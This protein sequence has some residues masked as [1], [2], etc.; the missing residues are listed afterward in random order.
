VLSISYTIVVHLFS[1][2]NMDNQ[3]QS[4]EGSGMKNK[5]T[6]IFL[7]IIWFIFANKQLKAQSTQVSGIVTDA[8]TDE[9]L[10]GVNILVKGTSTGA[11]TDAD[12]A[13]QL[14]M[15]SLQDTIV[16]SYIGYQTKEVPISGRMELKIALQPQ[17]ISGEEVVVVGYGEQSRRKITSSVSSVNMEDV[18]E[19]PAS[20]ISQTLSGKAAGLKVDLQSAQP[21]GDVAFQIRGSATG[22][23]PLIV[24]D[25][26]PTSDF[27]PASAGVFGKGSIDA[28]LSTLNPADIKSIDILKDASATAI[29][30]SKAAGGVILITTKKGKLRGESSFD[31]NLNVSSG[32]QQFYG[33]PDMLGAAEYMRETNGVMKEEWLY[34]SRKSVY[35]EVSK[36]NGWSEPGKF[37]P[38]YS[39]ETIRKFENGSQVG[40]DFV[41][42]VTRAGAV[43]DVN[44]SVSG[45][46][47]NTRIYSS[48][49]IY[50]QK[51]IIKDNDLTKYIGRLNVNQDFGD[52]L[53][54][55]LNVNYSQ[56]NNNN[57]Q[58]GNGGLY[59]NSGILLSALQFDPTLPVRDENGNYQKNIRQS[60]F[61]NPV[62][63]LD[64]SNKTE[65]E[66]FFSVAHLKYDILPGLYVKTQ[67]G[68]DRTKSNGYGY[69][70]TSTIAGKSYNGRADRTGNKNTNYQFQLLLNY[71]KTFGNN[72]NFTGLLGTEY[73]K[74]NWEGHGITATDFPY[75]GVRWNN[76]E[77]GANRPSV[78]SNGGASETASYFTR[79]S[80]NYD[81]KYF[82]TAN[83]RLDGSSNF[84]PEQQYGF[85]PGISVG[86][87]LSAEGF[88]DATRNWLDQLKLRVGYGQTGNDEI[89]SAFSDWYA[90]GAN[91]MWGN[92]VVSGIKIA[93]L[94]NPGLK[95]EKQVDIN[96]GVDFALFNNRVSGSFE[97]FNRVISRIL[98]HKNLVSSNPVDQIT[99]NLDA[100]KQTY[101]T[102]VTVNSKNIESSSFSWNSQLTYS[103]YRDRWLERDP[104][105]VL[106]I[107]ESP[108]QYFGELWY[109]KSDG[110]VEPG[111]TGPLNHIP[112]TVR[113]KDVDGYLLDENGNRVTDENGKPKYSGKPDGKID[114]A[115]LVKV[116]VN[117]P[118][119]IGFSN[120]FKYKN[121]DLSIAAYGM[122]NRWKT[123]S[124]KMTLGG[125]NVYGIV[126]IGSNIMTEAKDRWN[127]DNP[128]GSG[129]SALQ[130]LAKYGTGDYYL[131]KAWFIRVKNIAFGYTLPNHLLQ[132]LSVNKLRVYANIMNPFLFTPYSGMDPETD[133]Y[134]A[135]YPNQRTYSLGV[136]LNF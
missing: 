91:T 78:W 92:S 53:T 31:V 6:A 43:R 132:K 125:P 10:P 79:I 14:I 83:L 101:G 86:W 103:Y 27:N 46:S 117:T 9:T 12:G 57:V 110:L 32:V 68:F 39:D 74:Y 89:G 112:G 18:E 116:G 5:Y 106:G 11:S 15:A 109:Y 98:G 25:G 95:W 77:L 111:S 136:Q 133:S 50:D 47:K 99:Y 41:D 107:N 63:Y 85:F 113:I 44:L 121:F 56:I 26:M 120:N 66:R 37:T 49:N 124:T 114:A 73:M 2:L 58:I 7:L 97:Y 135:A 84:S 48:L 115:D 35:S 17:A 118:F 19:I 69:L 24:I 82:V 65:I 100:K 102:E 93:G 54:G 13:F 94:G 60:N 52:N 87:D 55:G 96:A 16:V 51:G 62:S 122:F 67:V 129:P 134:V 23:E 28:T 4:H 8:Q 61:P 3:L 75:D 34:K 131:E 88:M 40:T 22:R 119:T 90:P 71:D 105:Y 70:P 81:Y 38:Y 126:S 76:L 45:N 42:E 108:K 127:S 59:E 21:G 1:A 33:I 36:P 80:Y 20:S 29:Y 123:N 130:G 30:G 72:H 64:I 128:E 104:S